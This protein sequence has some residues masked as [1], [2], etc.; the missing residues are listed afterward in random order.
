M[1]RGLEELEATVASVVLIVIAAVA[2]AAFGA[3]IVVVAAGIRRE[4]RPG[5]FTL[6]QQAPN[7]ACRS[8]RK[9]TGV[10]VRWA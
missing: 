4:D 3:M 5:K 8:A 6:S 1:S 2:I 10:G 7:L 9:A